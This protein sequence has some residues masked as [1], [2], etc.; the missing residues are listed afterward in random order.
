MSCIVKV[1]RLDGMSKTRTAPMRDGAPVL[2][3]DDDDAL[4]MLIRAC[5]EAH[6]YEVIEAENGAQAVELFSEHEPALVLMDVVMPRLD[7]FDAC[8]ALRELPGAQ[9]VPV[10]MMTGLDDVVSIQKAYDAGATDFVTKPV[11]FALLPHRVSYLHRAG[12]TLCE[13]R[14]SERRLTAAQHLAR[15]GGWELD[16]ENHRLHVSSEARAILGLERDRNPETIEDLLVN[17]PSGDRE[18]LWN[19]FHD[20]ERIGRPFGVEHRILLPSEGERIIYQQVEIHRVGSQDHLTMTGMAQDV[21]ERSEAQQKIFDLAHF[22]LLTG[23]SNRTLLRKRV[24]AAIHEASEKGTHVAL[25]SIGIDKFQRINDSCGH[26]NGDEL[27][28]ETARRLE[29]CV[30]GFPTPNRAH[31]TVARLGGDEFAICL[32]VDDRRQAESIAHEIL[33]AISRPVDLGNE[34]IVVTASIG[35]ALHPGHGDNVKQLL[36]NADAAMHYV[37]RRGGGGVDFHSTALDE[38]ARQ[39]L[40][41]ENGL[42]RAIERSEIEVWYQPKVDTVTSR[43]C[44][45]EALARWRDPKRGMIPPVEFIALAE[46]TGLIA[47]LGMYV[48]EQACEQAKKWRANGHDFTVA[49]NLSPKQFADPELA[50]AILAQVAKSELS[51]SALEVEITESALMDHDGACGA[52]L[53]KLKEAGVGIALDDFGTGY[54]SLSYLKQFPIDVVKIDRSFVMDVTTNAESAAIAEAIL[55]MSHA[56]SKS[57]VAEGVET[58]EQLDFLRKHD[59]RVVQGYFYSRPLAA[60][61]LEAWLELSEVQ[62]SA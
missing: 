15:L 23:L 18:R 59:C 53:A 46:E 39:R 60:V 28:R 34:A 16:L 20:G 13:L 9:F 27:L 6:G 40:D 38:N 57:C 25:L 14:Q 50:E 62:K 44:G 58:E 29:E 47:P 52:T 5:L 4:R 17:V 2:I 11:N 61:D 41:M 37:K 7:G 56:M 35:V 45:V 49:V 10:V 51:P 19:A 54:A 30:D 31:T 55:G 12:E 33:S 24:E 1:K 8:R 42:R 32:P 22:D 26:D 3:A 48:L 36:K 43:V 21:T